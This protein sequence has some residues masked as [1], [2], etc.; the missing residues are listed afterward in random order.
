MLESESQ[1]S[2]ARRSMLNRTQ[3][4]DAGLAYV[5]TPNMN[6]PKSDQSKEGQ[7]R[8]GAFQIAEIG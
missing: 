5:W 7:Q 4:P 2:L 6:E 1:Y 8:L 3:V